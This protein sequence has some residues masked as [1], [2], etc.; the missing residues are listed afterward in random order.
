MEL[1]KDDSTRNLYH[2]VLLSKS[3]NDTSKSDKFSRFWPEWHKY[4]RCHPTNE[5]VYGYKILIRPNHYPNK[6]K[7]TQLYYNIPLLGSSLDSH[8]IIRPFDFEKIDAYIRTRK[9]VHTD[10]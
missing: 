10:N 8:S 7:F 6:E 3:P 2:Y 1:N 9:K 5:I 4:T